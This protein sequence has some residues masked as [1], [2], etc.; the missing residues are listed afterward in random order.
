MAI[1]VDM[2][3]IQICHPDTDLQVEKTPIAS[4]SL[5]KKNGFTGLGHFSSEEVIELKSKGAWK[6]PGVS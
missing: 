2:T 4:N 1:G 3:S 6:S 5:K